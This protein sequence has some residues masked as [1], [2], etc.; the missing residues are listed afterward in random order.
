MSALG[1]FNTQLVRF[2]KELTETYPEERDI[3]LAL[4]GIEGMKKIN[5]RLILEMFTEYVFTPLHEA[6]QR[7]D[8]EFVIEF[9]R[10]QIA[11]QFNEIS[12]AL[13]IFDKHWGSMTEV[14][15]KAIWNYLKVLC[16]LCKKA[17]PGNRA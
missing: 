10:K 7:E 4:E 5:P 13:L 11:N 6:I 9:A 1:G 15:Q 12:P 8:E 17:S 3:R 16:I 14:N 2:F